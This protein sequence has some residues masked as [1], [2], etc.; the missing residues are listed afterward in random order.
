MEEP[1]EAPSETQTLRDRQE[2]FVFVGPGGFCTVCLC[3]E[4]GKAKTGNARRM[5]ASTITW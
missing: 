3:P 2:R 4:P 5:P 1:S